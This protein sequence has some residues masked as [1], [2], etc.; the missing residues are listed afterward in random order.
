MY[1]LFIAIFLLLFC[2]SAIAQKSDLDLPL[3]NPGAVIHIAVSSLDEG[4]GNSYFLEAEKNE[5]KGDLNDALTMFGK[6]AFEFNS[7]KLFIRYGAALL[8]L[9]NIHFMLQNYT[10]AEQVIINVALK[11]YSR[12]GSRNG[13]MESYNQLG[14]IYLAHNKLT[15]SLWFYT[16]QGLI[17]RQINN[18]NSYI[19]SILGIARIKI[20]RK[21]YKLAIKDLNRAELLAQNQ[22][23]SQFK[24]Q[25]KDARG[26]ISEKQ[27]NKK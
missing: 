13:Q 9:S 10:E 27:N 26:L 3:A 23:T 12:I 6:A 7:S 19:D 25:I 8:R 22:K 5:K 15:E 24:G 16:Q 21:E 17:A 1:K 2:D 14:K 4:D 11:N 18:N 20:K